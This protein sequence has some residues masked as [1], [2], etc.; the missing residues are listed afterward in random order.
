MT[1]VTPDAVIFPDITG[2]ELSTQIIS[3]PVRI[4]GIDIA[5]PISITGGL[6]SV[7]SQPF[8][9]TGF[10]ISGSLVRIAAVSAPTFDTPHTA[11]LSLGSVV[12]NQVVRTRSSVPVS[13]SSS[14]SGGGGG[15]G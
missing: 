12:V 8:S 14:N 4:T 5:I 15:S 1:D 7:D 11:I 9:Q 3:S 2:V 13:S 6:L 10:V